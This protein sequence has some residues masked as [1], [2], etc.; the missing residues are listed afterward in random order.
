[1]PC[2]F[3]CLPTF[4]SP[5]LQSMEIAE[6]LLLLCVAVAVCSYVVNFFLLYGCVCVVLTDLSLTCCFVFSMVN[7]DQF[8]S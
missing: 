3:L 1:M 7:A 6:P 2:Q 4:S 5:T 8:P